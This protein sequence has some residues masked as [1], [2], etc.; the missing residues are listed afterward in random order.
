[1]R[2]P[3]PSRVLIVAHLTAESPELLEAVARR[4][5][6]GPCTFTLLVPSQAPDPGRAANIVDLG[7]S[8]AEQRLEAAIPLISE[9]AGEAILG[10]VGSHEPLVAVQDA[11]NLLGFDEVIISM[12]PVRVSRWFRLDLPRKVRALGVP[13]TE[14]ITAAREA[15]PTAA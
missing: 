11:L 1:M 8:E 14:V 2:A 5:A 13:V 7:I 15:D 4:V 3:S 12:L 10:V 6:Q 9:A